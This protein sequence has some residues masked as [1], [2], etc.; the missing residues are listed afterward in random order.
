VLEQALL[1]LIDLSCEFSQ[2]PPKWPTFLRKLAVAA[3]CTH[4]VLKIFYFGEI[5]TSI[6]AQFGFQSR[7]VEGARGIVGRI[8][9]N[10]L[11]MSRS[12]RLTHCTYICTGSDFLL[13]T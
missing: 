8:I 11:S 7:C 3:N 4:A 10:L 6:P 2:N 9:G 5:L 1:Q 12:A 13:N